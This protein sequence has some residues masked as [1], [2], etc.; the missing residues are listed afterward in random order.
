M[1]GHLKVS[2]LFLLFMVG[3][4]CP[5]QTWWCDVTSVMVASCCF[6][7]RKAL[8]LAVIKN[9]VVMVVVVAAVDVVF[10]EL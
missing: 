5:W 1:N 3:Q 8:M 4:M 2:I 6:Y 9:A 10:R 7:I